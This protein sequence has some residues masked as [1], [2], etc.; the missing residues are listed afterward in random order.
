MYIARCELK[1]EKQRYNSDSQKTDEKVK[2]ST[3][4]DF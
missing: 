3:L 2:T 1:T 4:P